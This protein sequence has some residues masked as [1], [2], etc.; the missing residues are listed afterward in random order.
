MGFANVWFSHPRKYG[1]GSRSWYV[2]G[3][4]KDAPSTR[5]QIW[6]KIVRRSTRI[7][8]RTLKYITHVLNPF[9]NRLKLLFVFSRSCSNHH[10]LIRKYG[11]NLCRQCFREYANDIGFKKVSFGNSPLNITSKSIL[12]WNLF[13]SRL[14]AGLDIYLE[15]MRWLLAASWTSGLFLRGPASKHQPKNRICIYSVCDE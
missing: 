14:A 7:W 1:Q 2:S 11:L 5:A 3:P 10:G 8:G 15:E 12:I 13:R 9:S 4:P 6:S